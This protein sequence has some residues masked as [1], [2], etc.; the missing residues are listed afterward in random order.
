MPPSP[1][2][3]DAFV[4]DERPDAYERVV[5]RL[6]ASPH[7]GERWGRHWLDLARY[8]DSNGYTR[9]FGR[10]IWK[11]REWVIEAINAQHA[12]RS[13]HDRADRRRHAAGGDAKQQLVATGFHRNTLI[14]EE[15]GTDQEQFR[16][17]AVVDR[18][19]T[20]GAV[21]LGLTVG[22]ARCH[23]HKY[24]PISQVEYYQ[25]FA[26]LNNCDEP[27]IEVPTRLQRERSELAR[28]E[29]IRGADQAAGRRSRKAAAGA[30][31]PSSANG[32]RPS[33]RSSGPGCRGRCKSPTT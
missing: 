16:V 15:G 5:D 32:K 13:V 17:E 14:N 4:A 8:A 22:C 29:E 31:K 24:D 10:Q 1:E 7:Y 26:L 21:W 12:V 28:R 2:E 30:W 25:L 6:L 33:R 23:A 27:T 18:V 20:T 19:N 3:V 9:D 11:Y